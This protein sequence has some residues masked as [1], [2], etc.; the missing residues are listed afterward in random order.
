[1]SDLRRLSESHQ[2]M[3]GDPEQG[4]TSHYS[5]PGYPGFPGFPDYTSIR[6]SGFSLD[7]NPDTHHSDKES[8]RNGSVAPDSAEALDWDGPDDP[9][10][11]MNWPTWKKV[12]HTAIPAVY[13]FGL[14]TGISTLVAAL[15]AIIEKWGHNRNTSLLPITMYTVGFIFG[16]CIA[17]PISDLHGRLV[18]YKVNMIILLICNAIAVASDN[19]AVL[20]I[21]R[22][23]ASLGGSGVMAVGAGTMS[24]LWPPSQVSRVGVAYLLAP[25]LGPSMGPLI[26][27]YSIK[28]YGDWKWGVWVV[29]C[30]LTPVAIAIFFSS[31]T[32]KKVI[33]KERAKRRGKHPKSQ[34][35]SQELDK[36]GKA[37]V[38]PWHMCLFEPVSLVLGLYSG[39]SFAMIFSF[40]GSYTYVYSTVYKFDARQTGLCYI[41]LIIGILFGLVTF[42]VFDATKYQKEVART[43][44]KVAPEHRLY[45][46][47]LGSILVPIGLFWYAWAPR[48][49]VHWIV[50]VLAGVP[51]AWGTM[52]SFLSCLAYLASA[53]D[54]Q[55]IASAVAAN[56]IFRFTLGAAFPNFVFQTYQQLG[57]HWAGSLFAF[58]SVAFIPVPWLL[59]WKGKA[60]RARSAY[61]LSS[62]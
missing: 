24:D 8:T 42:A 39:F 4:G 10:N 15:P 57:I 27:S 51:F 61:K 6:Y 58:I 44:D 5:Y 47:L 35:I 37:M 62:Y 38:R 14:T 20:V 52:A 59:F 28:Q 9:E 33:L 29:L 19:F 3:R 2:L 16:P 32:S 17:A 25:F 55:D 53:F 22:F 45:A 31:E 12:I 30:I 1:M 43:G 26:G 56:G 36:I 41:G 50:P 46:A 34:G 48:E 18:V 23:F 11:P 40:F 49:S 54:P 13:T 21:F 60:L 7:S